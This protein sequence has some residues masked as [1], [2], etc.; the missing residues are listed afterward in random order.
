MPPLQEVELNFGV[1]SRKGRHGF[2][3]SQR[4]LNAYAEDLGES[5]KKQFIIYAADGLRPWITLP[6]GPIREMLPTSAGLYV[7]AGDTAYRIAADKTVTTIG[8]IASSTGPCYMRRNRREVTQVGLVAIDRYYL[9]DDTTITEVADPDLVSPSTLEFVDGYFVFSTSGANAGK[10][11]TSA[12]DDGNAIA[13]LDFATAESDPDELV[14]VFRQR[15]ELWLLGE[16]SIEVWS[17]SGNVDFPFIRLPGVSIEIGCLAPRSVAAIDT[18]LLWVAN[19]ETVR[20]ADGYKPE[21]V[22]HADVSASISKETDKAAISAAVYT[23]LGHQFYAISGSNFTW[24]YDLTTGLWHERESLNKTRWRVDTTARFKQTN[25]A[26]DFETGDIYELDP[27]YGF[28][29]ASTP[30]KFLLRSP[31]IHKFPSR[32]QY[33]RMD[34]DL[35][36]GVGVTDGGSAETDP[37]AVLTYSDDGGHSWSNERLLTIGRRGQTHRKMIARKLGQSRG[38]GR[39]VEISMTSGVARSLM[40][41]KAFIRPVRP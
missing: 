4:F 41:S 39:I 5:G 33:G 35:V 6:T 24:V 29:G 28:E 1:Q 25:L 32:V 30:I 15:G 38:A 16:T 26:G 3:G 40:G 37:K 7:V 11:Q 20:L 8:Q 17:Q 19:D 23:S 13:A 12:L 31:V 9:I 14:R 10:F 27:D 21:V 34:F 22:S 18:R 2:D 36:P